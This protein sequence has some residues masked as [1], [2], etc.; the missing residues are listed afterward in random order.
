VL[1]I[2][3]LVKDDLTTSTRRSHAVPPNLQVLVALRYLASNSFQQVVGDTI[4]C[5]KSTVCRILNKFCISLCRRMNQFIKYPSGDTITEYRQKFFK[6][7][8]FP[9]VCGCVDGTLVRILAP[10][11]YAH[12]YIC[13]KGTLIFH[14]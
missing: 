6:A 4:Q 1:G 13:R 10:N 7:A 5:D 2:V 3:D 11:A 12:T 8:N 9:Q 14:D